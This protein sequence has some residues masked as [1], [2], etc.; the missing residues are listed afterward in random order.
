MF[1]NEIPRL[2]LLVS[3]PNSHVS[4]TT[5]HRHNARSSFGHP[6]LIGQET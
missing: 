6:N 4:V 3:E 5:L 2:N 1:H